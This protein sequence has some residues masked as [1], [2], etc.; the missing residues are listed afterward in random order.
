VTVPAANRPSVPATAL[1]PLRLFLGGAF[2]YAGLDKLL[3]P[4][5]FDAS[6]SAS[7]QAQMTAFA[8]VSP[9]APLVRVAQPIAPEIGFLIALAEIAVGL[10]A[11]SGLAFR[12]AAWMGAILSVLFFLTASWSIRPF[13]LGP[14]LPFAAGWISLALAGHGGVLVAGRLLDWSAGLA[15]ADPA[16]TAADGASRRD[17]RRRRRPPAPATTTLAVRDRRSVLQAGVLGLFAIM[18]ASLAIPFRLAGA[19]RGSDSSGGTGEGGGAIASPPIATTPPRESGP[20]PTTAPASPG[21]SLVV[22]TVADVARTG[23]RAFTVPFTAPAPL[24]AGDPGVIV[25][26]TDGSYVA[27]DAVCTHAGC[28]VQWDRQDNVLICPCHGAVFDPAANAAVLDGPT[29]QPLAPI[30]ITVDGQTGA[31][32]LVAG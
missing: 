31:I 1:L 17:R 16:A 9:I 12:L 23:A 27:Y 10:G 3:D 14:D 26:L 15:G 29:D 13:Y 6:S 25:R 24:P 20:A 11:L 8:R 19:E 30:A 32:S 2:L 4:R 18:A 21:G 28:T 7:I 22:A 5:F